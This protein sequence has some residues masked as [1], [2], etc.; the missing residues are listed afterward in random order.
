MLNLNIFILESQWREAQS[1]IDQNNNNISNSSIV[2]TKI[3]HDNDEKMFRRVNRSLDH[4]LQ[5]NNLNIIPIK[6]DGHCF[7]AAIQEF[8]RKKNDPHRIKRV[9]ELCIQECL[10]NSKEYLDVFLKCQEENANVKFLE[11]MQHL[12]AYFEQK[13]WSDDFGDLI[14]MIIANALCLNLNIF[15]PSDNSYLIRHIKSPK[16][17]A[18]YTLVIFYIC[19]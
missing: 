5:L 8:L 14:I 4:F 2:I 6:P 19:D 18:V 16:P 7:I 9:K 17:T 1:S 12:N 15:T 10:V 11:L 3:V 13:I